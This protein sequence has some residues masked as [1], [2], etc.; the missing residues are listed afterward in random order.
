ME[1]QSPTLALPKQRS[2]YRETVG[3]KKSEVFNGAPKDIFMMLYLDVGLPPQVLLIFQA[4]C[5][6]S[7]YTESTINTN[8]N[9]LRSINPD[10]YLQF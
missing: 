6:D 2:G 8:A 10:T 7:V 3:N 5:F 4:R 1:S 9:K